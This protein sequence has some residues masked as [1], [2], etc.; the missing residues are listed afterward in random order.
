MKIAH[1]VNLPRIGGIQRQ[2]A[3]FIRY[4]SDDTKHYIIG[5]SDIHPFH[6]ND[7]LNASEQVYSLNNLGNIKIPKPIRF[8]KEKYVTSK[9]KAVCPDLWIAWG[10]FPPQ[11]MRSSILST[12]SIYYERGRA[13]DKRKIT[14]KNITFLEHVDRIICVSNAAKR[15]LQLRW[16][17]RNK[18]I[19]VC[20]NSLR[21]SC[22]PENFS[23]K[24]IDN[25]NIINLGIAGRLVH[26][27][28]FALVIHAVKELIER[29]IPCKLIVAGTGEDLEASK[30]LV[31]SLSLE[32]NVNFL[33]LVNDM[34]QFYSQIDIFIFPSLKEPF[35]NV[36][37]EAMGHGCPVIVSGVDGLY[38]MIKGTGAGF[39][40]KPTIDINNFP[41]YGGTTTFLEIFDKAYDPYT[42]SIITPKFVD[43]IH[44]ADAVE[45]L[46]NNPTKFK[47]MSSNSI[48]T[49]EERY[50]YD[51][52]LNNISKIIKSLTN[53]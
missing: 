7:I 37:L 39:I 3:D 36:V 28:G 29:K 38:E 4:Y 25:N 43:P 44:I 13:W 11:T 52:Y 18:N 45:E 12:R 9:I 16:G 41:K 24:S 46:W 2:F 32:D 15:M 31:K 1:Y 23:I 8:L 33:D 47:E 6:R 42:D 49:I 19:I 34:K 21:P 40:I 22:K 10:N 5:Q 26:Y 53:N 17:I 14:K 48:K 50:D 30:K 27:K 51:T 20:W 35:P